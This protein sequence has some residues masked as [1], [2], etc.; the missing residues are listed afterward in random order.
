MEER[1]A[2]ALLLLTWQMLIDY[3]DE[4]DKN[5]LFMKQFIDRHMTDKK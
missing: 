5:I 3:P 4:K 1:F 2:G